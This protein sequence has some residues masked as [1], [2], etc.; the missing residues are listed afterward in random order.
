MITSGMDGAT[1]AA[2]AQLHKRGHQEQ[3]RANSIAA[4]V[5]AV[6]FSMVGRVWVVEHQHQRQHRRLPRRGRACRVG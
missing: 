2:A 6:S 1:K 5:V 3:L 4:V